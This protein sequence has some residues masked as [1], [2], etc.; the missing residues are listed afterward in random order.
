M[1]AK[2]CILML[3]TMTCPI[4]ESVPSGAYRYTSFDSTG[5][6]VVKGWFT[7]DCQDSTNIAGEWHFRRISLFEKRIGPQ[8][9]DD[10]LIGSIHHDSLG[11]MLNPHIRD[12]NV[13]LV[14]TLTGDTIRGEW[15][16]GSLPGITGNG[17]FEA[18]KK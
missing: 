6:A 16:W 4:F 18:V 15:F 2:I 5:V 8:V 17:T 14:G 11:I 3:F 13:W 10:S 12:D 1:K 7:I 9:G